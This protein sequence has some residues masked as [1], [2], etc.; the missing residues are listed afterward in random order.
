M[1]TET[2][3]CLFMIPWGTCM[4]MTNNLTPAQATALTALEANNNELFFLIQRKTVYL[5]QEQGVRWRD[6]HRAYTLT[7][8]H[9][10]VSDATVATG[11]AMYPDTDESGDEWNDDGEEGEEHEVNS[12]VSLDEAASEEYLAGTVTEW[13]SVH[14]RGI[15]TPDDEH[16]QAVAS[17]TFSGRHVVCEYAN[18]REA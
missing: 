10:A 6:V 3:R 2:G 8:I 1:C 9:E 16:L 4:A 14:R 18:D 12:E 5:A 15:I 17:Y 7:Q 11:S 13:S